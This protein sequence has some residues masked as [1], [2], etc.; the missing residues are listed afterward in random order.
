MASSLEK[1][2][3]SNDLKILVAQRVGLL[4]AGVVEKGSLE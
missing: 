4:F 1:I 3:L 2:V